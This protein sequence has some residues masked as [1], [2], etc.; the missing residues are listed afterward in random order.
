MSFDFSDLVIPIDDNDD[1]FD[2]SQFL[3]DPI[4]DWLNFSEQIL[5]VSL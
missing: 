4:Y 2:Y 5:Q 3:A 1:N